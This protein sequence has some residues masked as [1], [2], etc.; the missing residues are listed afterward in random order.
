VA[1]AVTIPYLA[2]L[3][4][5]RW[6]RRRKLTGPGFKTASQ[7]RFWWRWIQTRQQHRRNRQ[8]T[9][10][11]VSPSQGSNGGNATGGVFAAAAVVALLQAGACIWQQ[12]EMAAMARPHLFLAAA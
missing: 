12:A 2:P 3:L 8:Y 6:W 1:L 9:P 10:V 5:W 11:S 4:C 7:W